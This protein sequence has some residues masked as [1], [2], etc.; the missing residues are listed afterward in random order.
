MATQVIRTGRKA[1][2]VAPAGWPAGIPVPFKGRY[3]WEVPIWTPKNG[4]ETSGWSG[5]DEED[6]LSDDPKGLTQRGVRR[7]AREVA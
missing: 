1:S 4:W 7:V 6:E 3:G 5:D 2:R